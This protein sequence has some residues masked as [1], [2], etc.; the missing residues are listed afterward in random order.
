MIGRIIKEGMLEA[1]LERKAKKWMK[2][3]TKEE[4]ETIKRYVEYNRNYD[5]KKLDF[6]II[7]DKDFDH[8]ITINPYWSDQETRQRVPF[9][10]SGHFPASYDI[11]NFVIEKCKDQR[12]NLDYFVIR[13]GK[14]GNETIWARPLIISQN[15]ESIRDKL[16][17]VVSK[18]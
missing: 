13:H 7:V 9:P 10:C 17:D 8:L 18:Q 15:E 16:Y 12:Y 3:G 2:K 1:R 6:A 14:T 11:A 5:E 4:I